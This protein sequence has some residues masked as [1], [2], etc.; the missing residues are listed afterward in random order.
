MKHN[1]T[2]PFEIFLYLYLSL[3]ISISIAINLS[4]FGVLRAQNVTNQT[5]G[6]KFIKYPIEVSFNFAINFSGTREETLKVDLMRNCKAYWNS[7]LP[8]VESLKIF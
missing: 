1:V 5:L 2:G 4:I 8:S 7:I 6:Y 3:S